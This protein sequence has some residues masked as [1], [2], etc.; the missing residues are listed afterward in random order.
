MYVNTTKADKFTFSETSAFRTLLVTVKDLDVKTTSTITA[1]IRGIQQAFQTLASISCN[2][3]VIA[4]PGDPILG[5]CEACKLK[6][7]ITSS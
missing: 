3:K 5:K 4:M 2:K 6:Q 1:R 7:A